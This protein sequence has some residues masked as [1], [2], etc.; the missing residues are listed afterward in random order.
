METVLIM[1]FVAA[2]LAI[3]IGHLRF[4]QRMTEDL[5]RVV[6]FR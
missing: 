6:K 3:G 1:I 4:F 5:I 2:V